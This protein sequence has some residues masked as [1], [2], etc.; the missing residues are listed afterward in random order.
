MR[1]YRSLRR[2]FTL[3]EILIVVIILGI[4]AAIVIPQFTN[5]STEARQNSTRSQLQTL[6]SQIELYKLQHGDQ[7]PNLIGGTDE[8]GSTVTHWSALTGTST[9]GAGTF[10]PYLQQAPFNALNGNTNVVDGNGTAPASSACGFVYDYNSGNG[11]GKIF[12]T[13]T[14]GTSIFAE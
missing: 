8:P 4:L 13:D 3:V 11:T 6:R 1:S 2:G 12:A 10:G 9:F 14:N 7:L 5:A